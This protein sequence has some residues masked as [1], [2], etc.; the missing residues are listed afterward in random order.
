LAFI[1]PLSSDNYSFHLTT[2][3]ITGLRQLFLRSQVHQ[4][5]GIILSSLNSIL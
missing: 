4:R 5:Q 3:K 2:I 1:S